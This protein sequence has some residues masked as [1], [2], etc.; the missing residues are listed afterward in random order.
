MLYSVIQYSESS[1]AVIAQF[2][3]KS[4]AKRFV[5]LMEGME[6]SDALYFLIEKI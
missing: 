3:L 5:H 4:D 2:A 6:L 1:S